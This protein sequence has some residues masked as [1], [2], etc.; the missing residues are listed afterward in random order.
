VPKT[1]VFYFKQLLRNPFILSNILDMYAES[2]LYI[3]QQ[4]KLQTYISNDECHYI[5][6]HHFTIVYLFSSSRYNSD[7]AAN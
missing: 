1:K 4:N 2:Q 3:N 6:Q 7:A 5:I